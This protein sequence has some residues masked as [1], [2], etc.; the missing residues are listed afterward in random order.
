MLPK[1]RKRTKQR[2]KQKTIARV[3][4]EYPKDASGKTKKNPFNRV[5]ILIVY[6]PTALMN[7]TG[8]AYFALQSDENSPLVFDMNA[9]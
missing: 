6:E 3:F 8:T 1:E 9:V 4:T 5:N 2:R 7:P